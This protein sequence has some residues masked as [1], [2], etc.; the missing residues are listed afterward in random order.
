MSL[1]PSLYP[2]FAW[3]SVS[4]NRLFVRS[5]VRLFVRLFARSLARSFVRVVSCRVSCV[6]RRALC[7]VRRASLLLLCSFIRRSSLPFL[8]FPF[9]PLPSLP[10]PPPPAAEARRSPFSCS[11]LGSGTRSRAGFACLACLL[12]CLR[13]R[14]VCV[15]DVLR[16]GCMCCVRS[17]QALVV[18]YAIQREQR[19]LLACRRR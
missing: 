18:D 5:F 6:V 11:G 7:V 12:I 2:R 9:L 19:D 14:P 1:L 17:V 15:F 16:L 3:P 10:H 4:F 13:S 8:P